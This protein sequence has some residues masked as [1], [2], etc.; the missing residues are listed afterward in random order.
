MLC[1]N[2][3]DP[4]DEG[5]INGGDVVLIDEVIQRHFLAFIMLNV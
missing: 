5:S 2:I 3:S 4:Q 1:S